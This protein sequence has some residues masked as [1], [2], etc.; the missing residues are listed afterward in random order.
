MKKFV[1]IA[2]FLFSQADI[3][4]AQEKTGVGIIPF[5]YV[6]GSANLKDVYSIQET[7]T[8]AFVKTK[9]F[10]IVDRSKMDALKREKDLQKSEDFIDGNVIQQG[11]SLGADYL[12]SGHVI[13][14]QAER[15]ETA[16]DSRTGQVTITY[17]SKLS[18]ALKVIDVATGQVI[19]SETIEP[20][21]GSLL[22][23]MMGMA[24]S[25]PEAAITKA[26][27]GIVGKVD[28]FVGINFP[29]SFPIAEILE[30]DGKGS[31]TKILIAGGSGFGLKK[32][33]KLKVVEV[34]DMEVNGKKLQRKK[35]IGELKVSKVDDESF[36]TCSVSSGGVDINSKF[37]AKSKILI[38]TKD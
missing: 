18:I 25:T 34:V 19:V 4:T 29:V 16:P 17:K 6:T 10:N 1:L 8:N 38:M 13:A 12:I 36:S 11:V 7:V 23:G 24:P 31:A 37:E 2:A 20:K 21:A 9:R 32:G 35:E 15:M 28:E 27:S 33:D 14:A 30:K 5:T 22:G 3:L 26:I